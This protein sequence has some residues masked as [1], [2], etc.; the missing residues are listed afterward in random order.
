MWSPALQFLPN[1]ITN[2]LLFPAKPSVPKAQYF[3]AGLSQ[4]LVAHLVT[5]LLSWK[6]VLPPI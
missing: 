3:Y 4:P 1:G 2:D 5:L 6:S